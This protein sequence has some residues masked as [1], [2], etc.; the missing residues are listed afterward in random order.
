MLVRDVRKKKINLSDEQNRYLIEC[1]KFHLKS[2]DYLTKKFFSKYPDIKVSYSTLHSRY[3]ELELLENRSKSTN[4]SAVETFKMSLEDVYVGSDTESEVSCSL[5]SPPQSPSLIR[6]NSDPYR[7][8]STQ[9]DLESETINELKSTLSSYTTELSIKCQESE[10]YLNK[11]GHLEAD[12]SKLK[13][14]LK[15]RRKEF[16]VLA[17]LRESRQNLIL[18]KIKELKN[19]NLKLVEDVGCLEEMVSVEAKKGKK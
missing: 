5:E 13:R 6:R 9:C 18:E 8:T 7:N 1:F 12:N 2:P 4:R 11:C 15:K 3:K 16:R 14:M 10:S 19:C 17:K